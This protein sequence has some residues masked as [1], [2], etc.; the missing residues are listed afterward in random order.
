MNVKDLSKFLS[1][2]LRHQPEKLGLTLDEHGWANVADLLAALKSHNKPSTMADLEYVVENNDKKRFAFNAN[3]TKIRASQGHSIEINLGYAPI[4]PPEWLYHGTATRFLDSIL[5]EGLN[6]GNRHDV[7]LT[8]NPVT[9]IAVGSRYGK[10]VILKIKAGEMHAA[11]HL[12]YRS[13]N[14]VWLTGFV[15]PEYLEVNE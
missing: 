8:E 10:P 13:D 5:K 2:V 3:K 1:L 9:G 4:V 11:G 15:P 7:H 14:N 12:F 6:K